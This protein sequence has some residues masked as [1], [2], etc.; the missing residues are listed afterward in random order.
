M[1]KR[2]AKV[3]HTKINTDGLHPE[4]LLHSPSRGS[5]LHSTL[6]A[7]HGSSESTWLVWLAHLMTTPSIEDLRCTSTVSPLLQ[8]VVGMAPAGPRRPQ[9]RILLVPL[10]R[11]LLG[12][13]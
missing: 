4:G 2:N 12:P 1:R 9:A 5:G 3:S 6:K 11:S 10:P 8:G 13:G 7:V